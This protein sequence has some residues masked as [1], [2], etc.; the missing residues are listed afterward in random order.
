MV[1]RCHIA[2]LL[3]VV[4][5]LL[6]PCLYA[7]ER[8]YQTATLVGV[9]QKHRSRV[10]Y[11]IVNTPVTQE[12][13]F[14]QVSVQLKSTI[15]EGEYT[16]RHAEESLPG[17]WKPG[18]SIQARIEKHFMFLKRPDGSELQFVIVK[19]ISPANNQ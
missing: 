7:V 1:R 14:Y 5:V 11:Y 9:Q 6:L 4:V 2:F 3:A 16:P 19:R 13:P 12:D 15:Y 8:S 10:L 17:N 18:A